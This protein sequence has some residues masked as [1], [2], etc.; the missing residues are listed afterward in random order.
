MLESI[1]E[2][3]PIRAHFWVEPF[4]ILLVLTAVTFLLRG[5]AARIREVVTVALF[6]ALAVGAARF[7]VL[8]AIVCAPIAAR[9]TTG[10]SSAIRDSSMR[11]R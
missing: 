9:K 10:A 1:A 6:T 2:M 8:L 11:S 3:Q 4:G 7:A 5:R